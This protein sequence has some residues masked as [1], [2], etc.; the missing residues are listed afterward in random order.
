MEANKHDND[1]DAGFHNWMASAMAYDWY[2]K[3]GKPLPRKWKKRLDEGRKWVEN[4]S[5]EDYDSLIH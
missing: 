3:H 5:A 2:E 1:F 4:L